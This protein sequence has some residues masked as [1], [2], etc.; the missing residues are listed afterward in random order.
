MTR[1]AVLAARC[2]LVLG[3]LAG[4]LLGGCATRP[5]DPDDLAYYREANDPFEPLN[6]AVFA[7]NEA[8]DRVV[9]RPLAIGYRKA[10]PKGVRIGL[11][12]FSN[13]LQ[14]PGILINDLLQ[15]E[16]VR[17]RETL[18]RFLTNT[19]LGLGGLID[20]ASEAGIPYHEED[21]GQ[22]LAVWGV[23]SG[24]YVVLPLLG[25]TT[26]RDGIGDG[27]DA[28]AD[29]V[30]RVIRDEYGLEGSA[31]RYSV[32]TIDWRAANLEAVDELRRSS[33]D[34]YA[35]VRSAYR[36]RR[37]VEIR[38]GG[39]A[40]LDSGDAQPMLQFDS[41]D[42]D[43]NLDAPGGEGISDAPQSGQP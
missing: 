35:T 23:E 18:G 12:N 41:M 7:F 21:F 25:P 13:N 16:G 19:I 42:M 3:V 2:G 24:P 39:A 17:A 6:R 1:S 8:A 20:I 26:F 40:G 32:D 22:T 36:Q 11:R 38:N 34:F 30:G 4:L 31:V 9:L 5:S 10:V 29:P 15:G 37:T 14:S 27:V 28:M 43:M 33:L